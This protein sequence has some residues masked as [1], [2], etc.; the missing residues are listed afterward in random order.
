VEY[1]CPPSGS[2]NCISVGA[3]DDDDTITRSD[4]V[5]GWFT[6]PG[7]SDDGRKKPDICAP[8]TNIWTTNAG[9]SFSEVS[10]TSFAAPHV[11]GVCALL[12]EARPSITAQQTKAVLINST[13][14]IEG[15]GNGDW[16]EQGGWG[17]VDALNALLWRNYTFDDDIED[18]DGTKYYY[19]L[20]QSSVPVSVTCVWSREMS[21]IDT[22]V[23]DSPGNINIYLDQ[24][25]GSSWVQVGS[26]ASGDVGDDFV[27]DNVER[28]YYDASLPA[29]FYRIRVVKLDETSYVQDFTIACR[30]PILQTWP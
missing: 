19:F 23:A 12:K 10:G 21:D 24:R 18:E 16:D 8:G 25:Q 15:A 20:G 2:Y 1:L 26:S 14:D 7:P 13:V 27:Y 11:A 30:R 3:Y 22:A 5:I 29:V 4:D 28:I 9:D 17:A 6:S